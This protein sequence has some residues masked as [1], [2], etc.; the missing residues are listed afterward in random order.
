MWFYPP[1]LAAQL[2]AEMHATIEVKGGA[3]QTAAKRSL[4][5]TM[6]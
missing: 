1:D 6:H 4:F 3:H 2:E 5:G